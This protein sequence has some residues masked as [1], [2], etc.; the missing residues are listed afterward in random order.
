MKKKLKYLLIYIMLFSMSSVEAASSDEGTISQM[1]V[2]ASG[3]VAIQ[4]TNGFSN[5]IANN[6]CPGFNGWAGNTAA[7][8]MLKSALL[9]AK[10]SGSNVML[11]ISGC[12]AGTVWLKIIAAYIK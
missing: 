6:E 12:M 4:L 9:A 8:P 5:S 7:D 10:S 3:N 2:S 11:T 1:Y